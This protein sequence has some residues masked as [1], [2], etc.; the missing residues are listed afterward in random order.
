[1]EKLWPESNIHNK[2]TEVFISV[3]VLKLLLVWSKKKIKS[4][5]LSATYKLIMTSVFAFF[6][7]GNFIIG[8][9]RVIERN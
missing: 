6:T 3:I 2:P 7:I 5:T 8:N 4:L 1:M 9:R